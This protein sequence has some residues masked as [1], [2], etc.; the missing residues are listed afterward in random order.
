MRK[1]ITVFIAICMLL[2]IFA[3]CTTPSSPEKESSDSSE[4]EKTENNES[5]SEGDKVDETESE[6][7]VAVVEPALPEGDAD[8]SYT[9]AD[10]YAMKQYNDRENADYLAACAYFE[11]NGYTLYSK[12]DLGS[13][14][15]ATYVNGSAYSVVMIN[16]NASELYIGECSSGAEN[17]PGD[18]SDYFDLEDTTI[19]QHGTDKEN[20]MGYFIRLADGSFIIF[21]GGYHE[22]AASSFDTLV[23]LNGNSEFGIHIRA[24]FITHSH[25]DHYQMFSQFSKDYASKV[26]LDTLYYCEI[27]GE[28]DDDVAQ[29]NYL[30][31]RV[32]NDLARFEGA[33]SCQIHTGMSF[34]IADVNIDVLC[35]PEH[36]YKGEGTTYFNESSVVLRVTDDEGG[37]AIIN[38]DIGEIGC[39]F[40]MGCYGEALK[41][42]IVQMAHHGVENAPAV[43]YDYIQPS[44]VFIPYAKTLAG[45]GRAKQHVLQSD[46]AKEILSHGC[47]DITR[48]LSYVAEDPEFVDIMPMTQGSVSGVRIENISLVDGVLNYSIIETGEVDENG[49]S[50]R[51]DAYFYYTLNKKQGFDSSKHNFIKIVMNSDILDVNDEEGWKKNGGEMFYTF[52]DTA[53]KV[54]Q[55]AT[56]FQQG[57][58]HEDKYVVYIYLGDCPEYSDGVV[59]TLRFDIGGK[60]GQEITV[61]SIEAFTL[62]IDQVD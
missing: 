31:A 10:G 55:G 49:N 37:A 40:M 16:R 35:S 21:D 24:W 61:Y 54:E 52:G 46:Y 2:S 12:N 19:T 51:V 27:E 57:I 47:G 3:S 7:E 5:T 62:E 32:L 29:D 23:R 38:G 44:T 20:G 50:K 42:N 58:T 4:T 39:T 56:F 43:Y 1:F 22:D 25:G 60:Q 36:T 13:A 59:R 8:L 48:K 41:S 17:L 33:K 6:T 28:M 9:T 53:W 18:T 15:S 34:D 45:N 26:T 14:S 11:A 30:N